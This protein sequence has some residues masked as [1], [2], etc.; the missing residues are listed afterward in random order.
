ML[1]LMRIRLAAP[2]LLTG[3]GFLAGRW[4]FSPEE[5]LAHREVRPGK[6]KAADVAAAD[7][8]DAAEAGESSSPPVEDLREALKGGDPLS[9]AARVQAWLEHATAEDFQRF[10]DAPETFPMPPFF[11]SFNEVFREKYCDAMVERW[12]AFDPEHAFAAMLRVRDSLKERK[13][14]NG[15]RLLEAAARAEP[16]RV[17]D[18]WP[19]FKK[20]GNLEPFVFE[21]AKTLGAKDLG[22]ARA[23][24][25]RFEK[26]GNQTSVK[27]GII[28]GL[29]EID[30]LAALH[31]GREWKVDH[32]VRT[33]LLAAKKIGPGVVRQVLASAG[34]EVPAWSGV[35]ALVLRNPDFAGDAPA[36]KDSLGV[37][38]AELRAAADRLPPEERRALLDRYE[39][40]PDGVREDVAAALARRRSAV[41]C[42]GGGWFDHDHLR[43]RRRCSRNDRAI[44]GGKR[45][46]AGGAVAREPAAPGGNDRGFL[47]RGGPMVR[48]RPRR[49]GELGRDAA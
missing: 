5:T 23:M 36:T 13:D 15:D 12:L 8:K 30:P 26:P 34:E 40:L 35:A 28:E 27:R 7:P 42:R 14:Y 31:L 19:L 38:T 32:F 17:L 16:E 9:V 45:S 37:T 48:S 11:S 44:H 43:H 20:D 25:E 24:L 18:A 3:L 4:I 10:A 33:A 22:K 41:C 21:A 39:T 47:F 1:P 2:L 29:A 49:G 46:G 6:E